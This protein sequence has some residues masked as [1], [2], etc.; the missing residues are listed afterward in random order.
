M[1]AGSG[2][3]KMMLRALA[4]AVQHQ[5]TFSYATVRR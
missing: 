2:S 1:A 4:H 5:T 3:L